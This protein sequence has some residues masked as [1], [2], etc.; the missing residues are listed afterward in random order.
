M[1]KECDE[2]AVIKQA[3]ERGNALFQVDE[4]GDLREGKKG[5]AERQ[6]D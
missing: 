5:D 2:E 6:D 4:I 1:R 3:V